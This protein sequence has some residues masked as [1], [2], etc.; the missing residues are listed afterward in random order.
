MDRW[1]QRSMIRG[2]ARR[3]EF[4][5]VNV[6]EERKKKQNVYKYEMKTMD[7]LDTFQNKYT[8]T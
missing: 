5:F 3:E 6:F 2:M 4:L 1:I 8:A 7:S